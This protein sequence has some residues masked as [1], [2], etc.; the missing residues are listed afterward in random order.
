MRRAIRPNRVL[1]GLAVLALSA[2]P[3]PIG[4]RCGDDLPPCPSGQA[5]ISGLCAPAIDAGN[6]GGGT[7]G[8]GTAGGGAAGAGANP[9]CD[10]GCA[11]WAVC[12]V[13]GAASATCLSAALR[14]ASPSDGESLLANESV[15]VL[16]S[17]LLP[18]GG[19]WPVPTPIPVS[20]N[21]GSF[22]TLTSGDAGLLPG[23]TDAG[24]GV[25]VV[26]WTD[27]GP[28]ISRDV[29]F[30]ACWSS[31]SCQ[32][33]LECAP[34]PNGGRC[35]SQGLVID[36]LT[37]DAGSATNLSS[38]LGQIRV[39]RL[40]GGAVRLTSVPVTGA[41]DFTGTGGLFTGSLPLTGADGPFSFVAGWADGGPS[42][43][44]TVIRDTV[45]PAVAVLV[46]PRTGPDPD[47]EA[48]GAWKKD[49]RALVKVT[50][51]GGRAA[52]ASDLIPPPGAVVT[53]ELGCS[54][55]VGNCRCFG[56]DLSASSVPGMRAVLGLQV[57][58]I[59]DEAGN[60]SAIRDA[61]IEAT[62]FAW[63]RD[64]SGDVTTTVFPLAVS[65][66]G[67]V[68]LALSYRGPGPLPLVIAFTPRGDQRPMSI[69]SVLTSAPVLQENGIG[70]VG[71][72]GS[73]PQITPFSLSLGSL[74]TTSCVGAQ[75]SR[76][77]LLR[78][79]AGV[80]V[81]VG[82][83]N[84]GSLV[85]AEATCPTGAGFG[86]G[87]IAILPDQQIL[88]AANTAVPTIY[89]AQID[90]GTLM[91]VGAVPMPGPDFRSLFVD[92]Q[93]QAGGSMGGEF[94]GS[95][96]FAFNAAGTISSAT[97]VAKSEGLRSAVSSSGT[98]LFGALVD[99]GLAKIPYGG[100]AQLDGG[101]AAPQGAEQSLVTP[102]LG[103]GGLLYS[104]GTRAV[105]DAGLPTIGAVLGVH[106]QSDL[107]LMW[108]FDFPFTTNEAESLVEPA[109]DTYRSPDGG[110]DC[111]RPLGL[112]Y[113]ASR[114][115]ARVILRAVLVDSR[116]LDG[117]APWPKFQRDNSN[118]ANVAM[119]M[120]P[121]SCP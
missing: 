75:A 7:A 12:V 36:W 68:V 33:F 23:A 121:W 71:T 24:T 40:D 70:W 99:G 111:S 19:A 11:P 1:A 2:C 95:G 50:V 48:P 85:L 62:R 72:F 63:S 37:P 100:G 3:E 32:P 101:I 35:V 118:S 112:L 104:L 81:V 86:V 39:T 105:L 77:G 42:Q 9:T 14:V 115:G 106:R 52:I 80:D 38:V 61:G 22:T 67:E 107:S 46:Q 18:D 59:L 94:G 74:P 49:D 6:Q 26:G 116:G 97:P 117:T 20:G 58:P 43:S 28:T 64:V 47:P 78:R 98:H 69:D 91:S 21:W 60:G 53:D 88:V 113:V 41:A 102:V 51:D 87:P 4:N 56:V 45:A 114:V 34:D 55:C 82:L 93:S 110:R 92:S 30:R 44:L 76:L 16:A 15:S 89:K 83:S 90:G 79:D 10:G 73:M 25:V 8:G 119:P 5:C 109:L 103:E 57:S 120:T 96:Q 27:G 17:L 66:R 31:V 65:H 54:S 13:T 29:S 108:K 84:T